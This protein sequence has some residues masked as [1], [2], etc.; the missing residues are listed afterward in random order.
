MTNEKFAAIFGGP[1]RPDETLLP[2]KEMDLA[3]PSR[4]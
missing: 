3:R 2:Q 1:L 4:K